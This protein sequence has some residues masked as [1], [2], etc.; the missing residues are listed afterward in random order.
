MKGRD[1]FIGLGYIDPKFVEEAEC[2]TFQ[3]KVRSF[4]RPLLIAAAVGLAL[5]LV[6]CGIAY[7]Q[8]WFLG[9][10]SQTSEA[11]LNE[12]QISY[13]TENEQLFTEAATQNEWTVELRSAINDGTKAYII[14]G[15]SAPEGIRLESSRFDENMTM[16]LLCAGNHGMLSGPQEGTPLI[17]SEDVTWRS[18]G[19]SWK[20]D[21]DGLANTSNFVLNVQPNL[22]QSKPDPFSPDT[23]YQI[24]IEDIVEEYQDA[25]YLQELRDGKYK[26]Q[27][28]LSLTPEEAK[29]ARCVNVL[30]E[31][32]WDFT[33][34]FSESLPG[35]ELLTEPISVQAYQY[36]E[37]PDP[38]WETNYTYGPTTLSSF[39]LRPLGATISFDPELSLHLARWESDE[40]IYAVMKDGSQVE[41]LDRGSPDTATLYLDVD[42]PIVVEDVDHILLADGVAIP[43]PNLTQ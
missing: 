32:S 5:L 16:Y 3:P 33:I 42:S 36:H 14:L 39:V 7:A 37:T 26:D 21:G 41:L 6:G 28:R 2:G 9:Y 35:V 11:P 20:D 22:E 29:R 43:V 8:G 4:K 24:H 25:E 38:L 12:K 27:P 30:G 31:G 18:L 40:H 23:E 1:L 34:R 13:I 15:V 19:W 10:F 17:A